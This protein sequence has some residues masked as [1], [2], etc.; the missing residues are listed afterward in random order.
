[1]PT[2]LVTIFL[3]H[4]DRDKNDRYKIAKTHPYKG[5]RKNMKPPFHKEAILEYMTHLDNVTVVEGIEADDALGQCVFNS[6]RGICASID[7]DLLMVPGTHYNLN[8]KTFV[9]ATD[10]GKLE[11]VTKSYGKQLKGYGF[12]WF[13]AQMLMGDAVDNIVGLRG[14]GPVKTFNTLN[15]ISTNRIENL[16]A[17]VKNHYAMNGENLLR[18]YENADLLWIRRKDGQTFTMWLKE[19]GIVEIINK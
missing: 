6:W 5:N 13:C 17:V 15:D 12:V 4:A 18:V 16:W 10:P 7:K 2:L 11:L 14:Y 3:T 19:V 8:H 9:E 1:V